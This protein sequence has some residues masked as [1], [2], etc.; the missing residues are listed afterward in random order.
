LP[1]RA[2]TCVLAGGSGTVITGDGHTVRWWDLAGGSGAGGA[3]GPEPVPAGTFHVPHP[4]SALA[5]GAD[6]AVV[7]GTGNEVVVLARGDQARP[8]S[9]QPA[10]HAV[11]DPHSPR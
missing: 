1:V 7:V 2:I 10:G 11:T 6:G 4:V 3:S 8:V 5:I 9:G